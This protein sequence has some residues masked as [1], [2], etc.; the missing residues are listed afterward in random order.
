LTS[1]TVI[2]ILCDFGLLFFIN[3]LSSFYDLW[4]NC[5]MKPLMTSLRLC[6]LQ[7]VALMTIRST[8][9]R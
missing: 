1:N 9:K 4:R 8:M 6:M 2:Y 7:F 3:L 5:W